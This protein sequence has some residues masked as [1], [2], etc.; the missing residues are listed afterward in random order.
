MALLSTPSLAR[1]G[2][3]DSTSKFGVLKVSPTTVSFGNVQVGYS[4]TLTTTL[5]NT[6]RGNLMVYYATTMGAGFTTSGLNVPVTLAPTQS[7]TFSVTF[8]P[9][10][11]GSATGSITL[12]SQNGH[13]TR[14]VPL[15]G[16]GTASGQLTVS[17][18]NLDFGNVT[19]GNSQSLTGTLAATGASVVVSSGSSSSSE[20]ALSGLSFP[21]TISA[22]Q[23]ASFTM[24]FT[25]Q[26]SGTASASL[27]L[28]SDAANSPTVES[29]TG[30]GTNPPHH[31]VD[32]S[33]DPSSSVVSGYDV[34]RSG[35]SGGPYTKITSALDL[36]TTYA[37]SS[38]ES[39]NTYYYVT[40]AVDGSGSESSYSNEVQA[41]IPSP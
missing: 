2:G 28:D 4:K 17:P 22:G 24:T 3:S 30:T 18:A 40:T 31:T 16:S 14:E 11:S 15:T 34:Y 36:S 29:F 6:G 32:L 33:W 23:S 8:A 35:I 19:V 38:V 26:S 25:P 37:D 27:S 12:S 21:L 39:G 1:S 10:S 41:S 13:S 7:F 20:F 5:S 9:Q